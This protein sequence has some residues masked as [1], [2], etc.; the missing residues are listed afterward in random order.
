MML[1]MSRIVHNKLQLSQQTT[2]HI[3]ACATSDI[4]QTELAL[5]SLSHQK[6]S[7]AGHVNTINLLL[8]AEK[9]LVHKKTAR[10]DNY[11][12]TDNT[13]VAVA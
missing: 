13:T 6:N 5:Q 4:H 10:N 9:A 1:Q 7:L 3:N 8:N 11:S 12:I 2:D